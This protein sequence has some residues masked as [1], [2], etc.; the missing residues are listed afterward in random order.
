M[1]DELYG[2]IFGNVH[3]VSGG[4]F[5]PA[6]KGER[7]FLRDIV[8][9]IYKVM[10]KKRNILFC[11]SKDCFDKL[12]WPMDTG[13]DFFAE[14]ESIHPK[15]EVVDSEAIHL[16]TGVVDSE[17]IHPKTEVKFCACI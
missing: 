3:S 17:T 1:A 12:G 13:A 6:Y 2:T 8:T 5:E 4:V 9:P 7:S 10:F 15:T 16:K 11:R 14:S